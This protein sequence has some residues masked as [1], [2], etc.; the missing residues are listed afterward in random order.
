MITKDQL[1]HG[2]YYA[3]RSKTAAVARWN[4]QQGLFYTRRGSGPVIDFYLHPSDSVS[5]A[6]ADTFT[7]YQEI[8]DAS[9]EI[10]ISY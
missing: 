4:K 10:P 1:K 5:L 3:G 6:G 8:A 2:S 9:V 7:P